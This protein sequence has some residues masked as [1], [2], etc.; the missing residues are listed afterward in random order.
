MK[1]EELINK[2]LEEQDLTKPLKMYYLALLRLVQNKPK[3]LSINSKINLNNVALEA[4]RNRGAIKGSTPEIV[5]LK[6]IINSFK[7]DRKITSEKFI[8]KDV[9]IDIDILLQQ[10]ASLIIKNNDLKIEIIRLNKI[11]NSSS[12][13]IKF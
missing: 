6:N 2:I 4:G 1:N 12:N 11:I 7:K 3:I 10:L 8:K 9:N 13:I 5:E